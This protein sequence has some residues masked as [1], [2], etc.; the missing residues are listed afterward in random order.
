MGI[1]GLRRFDVIAD[2]YVES[3]DGE[4]DFYYS[5]PREQNCDDG[6]YVRYKDA[7]D[8]IKKRDKIIAELEAKLQRIK[9]ME[10]DALLEERYEGCA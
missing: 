6:S 2:T 8:E 9:V 10:E 4:P 3:Y 1:E 5:V 7:E